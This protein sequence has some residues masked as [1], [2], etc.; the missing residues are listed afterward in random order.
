MNYLRIHALLLGVVSLFLCNT[1]LQAQNTSDQKYYRYFIISA[2]DVSEPLMKQFAK[3]ASEK[4]FYSTP[5]VCLTQNKILVAVDINYPK[6][7]EE[8]KEEIAEMFISKTAASNLIKVEKTD[9]ETSKNFC[10]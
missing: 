5:Q 6:R 3:S 8:I 2:Q 4:S 10:K 7:V 9:I 1:D